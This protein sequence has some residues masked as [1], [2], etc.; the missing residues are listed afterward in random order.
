MI[1]VRAPAGGKNAVDCE[2]A[3]YNASVGQAIGRHRVVVDCNAVF[4]EMFMVSRKAMIGQSFQSIYPTE[5]DFAKTGKRITPTLTSAD[6]YT[7]QR[8]TRRANGDLF[9]V[10]VSGCVRNR[11][12]PFEETL[13]AFTE[14]SRGGKV[15]SPQHIAMTPRER[16]IAALLMERR[17][18]KEIGKALG[19]SPRTADLYKAWLLRKCGVISSD[20]LVSKLL[21]P[22]RVSRR[23]CDEWVA[24]S[25]VLVVDLRLLPTRLR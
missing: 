4:E 17:S 5:A 25:G 11:E 15:E 10:W 22:V 12:D 2:W 18:G 19:I 24:R 8:V 20:E 9:W 7:D 3:F 21:W 6:R 13:R 14:L 23:C 16:D 1:K